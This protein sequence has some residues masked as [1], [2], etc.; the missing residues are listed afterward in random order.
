[1]QAPKSLDPAQP[2]PVVVVP[3]GYTQTSEQMYQFSGY[4]ELAADAGFVALFPDGQPA[5]TGPWNIGAQACPSV[6][7]VLPVGDGDDQ[8][9]LDAMLSFVEQDQCIDREHVFVTGWSM[10]GYLSHQTGCLR[11][12][13]RAIGPHSA[14]THDLSACP[15]QHKPVIIFHGDADQ[16]IPFDCGQ[17]ARERWVERNGCSTEVDVQAVK[18]GRCEFHRGCPADGQVAF[19]SFAG[20]NHGW[21]GG[22]DLQVLLYPSA[23][24][25]YESASQLGWSFFKKYAW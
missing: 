5:S 17:Q 20:M 4:A 25:T 10:G 18:N 9:F 6:F 1:M 3:H 16:L 12:D 11:K 22:P 2:V 7:G 23:Y 19:C 14:G 13:I 21:A 8:A 24:S 15:A